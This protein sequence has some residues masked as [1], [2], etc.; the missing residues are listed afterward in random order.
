MHIVAEIAEHVAK[1]LHVLAEP[2]HFAG[3]I[4]QGGQL[5]IANRESCA[6]FISGAQLLHSMHLAGSLRATANVVAGDSISAK[7][8]SPCRHIWTGDT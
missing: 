6:G 1:L 4:D 3:G 8:P 5:P 2:L 7:R